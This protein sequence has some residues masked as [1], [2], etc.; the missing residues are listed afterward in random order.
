MLFFPASSLIIIFFG[1]ASFSTLS[2][3]A[4]LGTCSTSLPFFKVITALTSSILEVGSLEEL[5]SCTPPRI[6][7]CLR[8]E[9]SF[10]FHLLLVCQPRSRI[11][12]IVKFL[13]KIRL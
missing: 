13:G 11:L 4:G 2:A 7:L 9:L 1:S 5:N 3:S 10:F 8:G 6:G 12:Q